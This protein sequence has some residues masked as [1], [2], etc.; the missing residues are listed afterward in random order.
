MKPK[1]TII[2]GLVVAV[3]LAGIIWYEKVYQPRRRAA[4]AEGNAAYPGLSV[5]QVAGIELRKGEAEV[6]LAKQNQ[7]WVVASEGDYPADPDGVSQML[8]AAKELKLSNLASA[9]AKTHGLFAVTEEKGIKVSF[10][11]A[12]GK[13][14]AEFYVG[15][16]GESWG[17]AYFRRAGE[18]QTYLA[19]KNLATIFDRF[20]DTWKDKAIARFEPNEARGLT[21]QQGNET[22]RL[23]KNLAQNAWEL[24]E[25][26]QR[27]PASVSVVEGIVRSF[28]TLR[29]IEFPSL[30][31]KAA[32]LD[33]PGRSL[34][35]RLQDN[36]ELTLQVGKED[37]TQNRLYVKR[38]DQ[39]T[40]FLVS[41]YQLDNLFKS[42]DQLR[43]KEEPAAESDSSFPLPPPSL[44]K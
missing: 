4:A 31:L 35:V 8:D 32:G 21:L 24:V 2:L 7:R 25:G 33:K 28:S 12:A 37:S 15:K 40:L 27:T 22:L 23:E 30:D 44:D 6:R 41:K 43:V 1:H 17:T 3:T 16:R 5:D 19:A 38:A 20:S 11:D 26:E 36:T 9:K 14:L 18:D 39:P 13:L 29:T 10:R 34:T 42:K